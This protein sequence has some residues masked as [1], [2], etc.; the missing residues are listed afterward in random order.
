MMSSVA[1][2]LQWA[3]SL[4][5]CL[6]FRGGQILLKTWPLDT[7]QKKFGWSFMCLYETSFML[8]LEPWAKFEAGHHV[9]FP[10]LL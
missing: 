9:C 7:L 4:S 3:F 6:T 2:P 10:P 5:K 1:D 8:Q